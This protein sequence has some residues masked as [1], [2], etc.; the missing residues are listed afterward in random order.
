M[1]I[2]FQDGETAVILTEPFRVEIDRIYEN[3][4]SVFELCPKE[5]PKVIRWDVVLTQA[6]GN[7]LLGEYDTLE[8]AKQAIRRFTKAYERGDL[9]FRVE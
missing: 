2:L 7:E 6:D 5:A 9:A 8:E 3:P 4:M 1:L